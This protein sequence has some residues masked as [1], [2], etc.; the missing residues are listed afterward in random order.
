MHAQSCLTLCDPMDCSL[1]GS[2]IHGIP[3]ARILEWVAISSFRGSCWTRNWTCIPC[4]VH[5]QAESLP[6]SYLGMVPYVCL[7]P[8]DSPCKNTGMSSYSLLHGI[9]P[10]QGLNSGLL[11]CK[12]ILY[13]LSHQVSPIIVL[14]NSRL[15]ESKNARPWIEDSKCSYMWLL[16]VQGSIYQT[17]VLFK[18]QIYILQC[19]I[20]I[21]KLLMKL[22]TV[23]HTGYTNLHSYQLVQ[24]V[25]LFHILTEPCFFSFW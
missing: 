13:H 24:G 16:T 25:P 15:I 23:C 10:T 2:Y 11:N 14:H 9:F 5:W 4:L 7:C 3:Q 22:Y 1:P 20:Y 21:W 18:I 6:L 8:Q 12:K 17:L 19:Y